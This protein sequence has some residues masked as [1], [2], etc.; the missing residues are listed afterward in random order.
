MSVSG[1]W[2]MEVGTTS[3]AWTCPSTRTST[4]AYSSE[5]SAGNSD[6]SAA[7]IYSNNNTASAIIGDAEL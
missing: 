3:V 4:T 6:G 7:M 1:A 5:Q 2:T